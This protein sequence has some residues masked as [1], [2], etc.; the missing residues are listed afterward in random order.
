MRTFF[1]SYYFHF[2]SYEKMLGKQQKNKGEK[3]QSTKYGHVH[4]LIVNVFIVLYLTT[5]L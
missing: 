5:E 2:E 4:R 3:S 1:N